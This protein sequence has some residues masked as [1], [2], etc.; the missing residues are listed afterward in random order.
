MFSGRSRVV[1]SSDFEV[2]TAMTR[3]PDVPSLPSHFICY[4]SHCR[5]YTKCAYI[6][7]AGGLPSMPVVGVGVCRV[8]SICAT[9]EVKERTKKRTTSMIYTKSKSVVLSCP[10]RD[11]ENVRL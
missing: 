6:N 4:I 5:L 11:E 2:P 9:Q 7:T 10:V 3:V 1:E 8:L